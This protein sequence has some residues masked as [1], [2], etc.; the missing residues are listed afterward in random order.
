MERP[1]QYRTW[2]TPLAVASTAL[3]VGCAAATI[4]RVL[5]DG[6]PPPISQLWQAPDDLEARDLFYGPG[7]EKQAPGDGPFILEAYDTTGISPGYDVKDANGLE[8]SAKLGEEVHSEIAASR[9]LWAIGYHQDPMYYVPKWTLQGKDGVVA[10]PP[11]RFRPDPETREVVGDWSWRQNPFVGTRQFAGLIVANQML[12]NWDWKTNN[13]K[14]YEEKSGDGRARRYV[15]RDLGAS[16][17]RFSYPGVLQKLRLRGI[18]QGTKND[19]DGF[20]QQGF[21]AR[22]EGDKVEFDYR[23]I[24]HDLLDTVTPEDVRWTCRLLARLSDKQ[25]HDAFRAAGFNAEIGAR[26]TRK[27]KEKIAQ[28]LSPDGRL[29]RGQ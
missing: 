13:N 15:V 3:A 22:V 4:Q 14:I 7:N 8:W 2:A 21:I 18:K 11:A 10:Q 24:H 12:N 6:A 16:L 19:I 20:E 23:G 5:P 1:I 26:Y 27:L 28:G 9:I 17:G 25:W 29:A